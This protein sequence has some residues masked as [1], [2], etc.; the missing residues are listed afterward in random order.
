MRWTFNN[1]TLRSPLLSDG[2]LLGALR[3]N[4]EVSLPMLGRPFPASIS[5]LETWLE[6]FNTGVFPTKLGWT[7]IDDQETVIGF[8]QLDRIDWLSSHAWFGI[9]V[10]SPYQKQGHAANAT[11]ELVRVSHEIFRLRQLRLE[12]LDSNLVAI[13]LYERCGFRVEARFH[14]VAKTPAGLE[15]L[16]IMRHDAGSPSSVLE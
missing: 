2:P 15:D 8:S 13:R 5:G 4:P 16:I 9:W 7:L 12:V 1:T 6:G 11:R 10:G 14:Q 3:D